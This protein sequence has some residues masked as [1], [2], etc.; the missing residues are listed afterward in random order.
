MRKSAVSLAAVLVLGLSLGGMALVQGVQAQTYPPPVGS[1]T[2]T[3]SSTTPAAGATTTIT[4][5]V[6]DNSGDPVDGAEVTFQIVSQPGSDA[7][8]ANGELET[9][10]TTD[11]NGVATAVLSVGSTAGNIIVETVS[12][13]KTSQVTLA[14]ASEAGGLP[15]TGGSP[16]AGSG[17]G[18]PP[19]WQIAFM[20]L[21]AAV[22]AGGFAVF[23]R[24]SKRT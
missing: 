18:M 21:G 8:W 3:A 13:E 14:V 24:R 12:G 22:L 15:E 20:A 9:T 5:T 16:S 6:L 4:A 17:S 23:V 7:Q 19:A 2:V 11:A 10:G 1:L